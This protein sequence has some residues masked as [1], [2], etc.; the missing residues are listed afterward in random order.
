M[1]IDN[2]LF[3][4]ICQTPG[5]PGFEGRIRKVVIREIQ[6]LVDEY[7]VDNLGNVIAFRKG[8]HDKSI[9]SAAHMDEISMIVKHIDDNG[10]IKFQ[11]LGGFDPK[12]LTAQK[13]IV[14]GKEDLVG[15][16][17]TKPVHVMNEEEKKKLPK[18][19][20]FFIDLGMPKE[21]VEKYVSVGDSVT[22]K[23]EFLEMGNHLTC[24]SIDNRA[25]VYMLIETLKALK[26]ETIPYDFYAVFSVQE[27]V[28]LRGAS[29]AAHQI[30]PDLG[31]AIDTTIAFDTPGASP[32]E[33]ITKLGEGA[34]IK[35]MDSATICDQRMVEYMKS[36]ADEKA[37]S[38]QMEVLTGGA[39]DTAMI[40][41]M[42]KE[43][44]I[45]GAISIPIRNMHQVIEMVNKDDLQA[46]IDLLVG[47]LQG[48]DKKDWGHL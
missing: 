2:H 37:I 29:T 24:K 41:R 32:Q 28:G 16:L 25:S 23:A 39:T 27:E 7:R 48:S 26:D 4:E 12:T 6:N 8:K 11:T 31:I 35:V 3:E 40:Q 36:V 15:V 5:A 33:M 43:G 9:M 47:C 13:V 1:S 38:Y 44:A 20:D 21:E 42:G 14:H 10:F 17:G 30:N 34:A 18:V 46:S 19:Q 22:R 45:A